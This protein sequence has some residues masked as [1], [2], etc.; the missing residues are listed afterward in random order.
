MHA[1]LVN[2]ESL[3]IQA[4]VIHVSPENILVAAESQLVDHVQRGNMQGS[5][6]KVHV[7]YAALAH[8]V[9]KKAL[10]VN[11]LVSDVQMVHSQFLVPYSAPHATLAPTIQEIM[12]H[13]AP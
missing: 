9:H 1:Q 8:I 11:V 13:V 3:G 7:R 2:L 12:L 4:L 10:T 6:V 5:W